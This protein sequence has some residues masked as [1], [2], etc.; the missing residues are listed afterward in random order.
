[1]ISDAEEAIE[2]IYA[3]SFTKIEEV[4]E[5]DKELNE[6]IDDICINKNAAC[7]AIIAGDHQDVASISNQ[8]GK[9]QLLEASNAVFVQAGQNGE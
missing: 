8:I 7:H 9:L 5:A 2:D 4:L 3:K 1:M 6:A